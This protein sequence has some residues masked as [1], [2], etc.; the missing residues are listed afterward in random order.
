VHFDAPA[1][2]PSA[3]VELSVAG[4]LEVDVALDGA[5]LDLSFRTP[6]TVDRRFATLKTPV[7]PGSHV[8]H[9]ASRNQPGRNDSSASYP[10]P[11]LCHLQ[12]HL[13]EDDSTKDNEVGLFPVFSR[14]GNVQGFRPTRCGCL[15]RDVTSQTFCPVCRALILRRLLRITRPF[16]HAVT[17]AE[18]EHPRVLTHSLN[19]LLEAGLATFTWRSTSEEKQDET[20]ASPGCWDLVTTFQSPDLPDV[21]LEATTRVSIPGD[22]APC[23]L[24]TAAALKRGGVVVGQTTARWQSTR[25]PPS[26]AVFSRRLLAVL[27]VAFAGLL[28]FLRRS[29]LRRL[30][31]TRRRFLLPAHA[32]SSSKAG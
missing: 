2:L 31:R 30:L 7:R 18:D 11:L 21:R 1:G 29:L 13:D 27:V 6:P 8:L 5:A 24:S 12:I 26:T 4:G 3:S 22:A 19:P 16:H 20:L 15:M 17:A 28:L 14:Q 23:L 10:P 25:A 9:V 32:V